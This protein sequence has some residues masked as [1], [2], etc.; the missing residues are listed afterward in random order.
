VLSSSTARAELGYERAPLF[1]WDWEI[2]YGALARVFRDSTG[3]DH[4]EQRLEATIHEDLLNGHSASLTLEV[5]HRMALRSVPGTRDRF[6]EGRALAAAGFG[7]GGAWTLHPEA[8]FEI[9]RY[10]QP[11]SV[12]D[13]DYGI[14]RAQAGLRR[15]FANGPG[16][17]LAPRAEWLDAP[18]CPGERYR[19]LSAV[20]EIEWLRPTS[21]W[22]LAPGA[23]HRTYLE[24]SGRGSPLTLTPHSSFSFL[25]LTGLVDQRLPGALRIRALGTLRLERHDESADDA[26]SLYFSLDAR[27]LF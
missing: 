3:R 12:L 25:E 11:D 22:S 20:C 4:V 6:V 1:G 9:T 23:G 21:W 5:D 15:E 16:V 17:T 27:R 18:W 10:D 26:R 24:P 2:A 19:E 7:L 13:F 8:Q 14:L